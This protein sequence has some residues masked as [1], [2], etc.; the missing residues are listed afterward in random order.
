MNDTSDARP[1][2]PVERR[3]GPAPDV[4]LR[5]LCDLEVQKVMRS[6]EQAWWELQREHEK[7]FQQC[8]AIML[9]AHFRDVWA[10]LVDVAREAGHKSMNGE[11]GLEFV[12]RLIQRPNAQVERPERSAAK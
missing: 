4:L 7:V 10:R 1:E 5:R 12:T 8:H 3:V 11:S 2:R 6:H 9:D